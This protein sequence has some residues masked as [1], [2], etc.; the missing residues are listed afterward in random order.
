MQQRLN[1]MI[2]GTTQHLMSI[3]P[4]VEDSTELNV[5]FVGNYY[6]RAK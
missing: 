2:V 5:A 4:T 1:R 3:I 6:A